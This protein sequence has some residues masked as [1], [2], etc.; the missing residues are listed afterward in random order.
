MDE[1]FTYVSIMVV[2]PQF[3]VMEELTILIFLLLNR[4]SEVRKRLTAFGRFWMPTSYTE[5][6]WTAGYGGNAT[7]TNRRSGIQVRQRTRFRD[8]VLLMMLTWYV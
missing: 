3:I 7:R 6:S 4:C 8:F 1:A 5:N 2:L